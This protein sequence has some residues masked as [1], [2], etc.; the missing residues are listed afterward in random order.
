MV[1]IK[2]FLQKI[3]ILTFDQ[4]YTSIRKKQFSSIYLLHGEESFFIDKLVDE[5][6][7]NVLTDVEKEFNQMV[8][9][10]KDADP[11]NIVSSAR[12]YPMMAS[13]RMIILK[14]AQQMKD[15]SSLQPYVENPVSST[16]LVIAHKEKKLDMRTSFAKTISKH[17]V[18]FE[19][20]SPYEN[21]IPAWIMSYAKEKGMNVS[22]KAAELMM[23][24]LGNDL[25]KIDN[26]LEKIKI[27]AK[28]KNQIDIEDIRNNISLSREYSVFELNNA[29][30]KKD[31][32]KVFSIIDVFSNNPTQYPIQYI[33]S[34]LYGYFTKLMIV[35][36]NY[37]MDE[38]KL[39]KLMGLRNSYFLKEYKSATRNYP[40]NKMFEVFD[41]L[42]EYDMKS[43]GIGASS[44]VTGIELMKEMCLKILK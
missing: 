27:A 12:Q 18:V 34:T 28:D 39:Y 16:I 38:N 14:E 2:L 42:S 11:A 24:L 10:G 25:G 35:Y 32:V 5:F 17:G 6:Q 43:K 22:S 8:F 9:F 33:I 19:S 4:L 30:G 20:K 1:N 7:N 41:I 36:D 31:I 21:K 13:H 44:S 3:S 40:K 37:R 23:L 26:E 29:L 15:I